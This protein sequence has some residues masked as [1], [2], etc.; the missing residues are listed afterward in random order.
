MPSSYASRV[1]PRRFRCAAHD[2]DPVIAQ[3]G[4]VRLGLGNDFPI[5][6]TF[7]S[8]VVPV[9][10]HGQRYALDPFFT[11]LTGITERNIDE[12]GVSLA[13]ALGEL[14]AFSKGR[15]CRREARTN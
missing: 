5:L 7:R 4:A 8:Y 3:I 9:D 14:D 1:S 10:R 13:D 12:D 15:D 11:R 6:D 2:P